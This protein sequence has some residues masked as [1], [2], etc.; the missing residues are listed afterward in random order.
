MLTNRTCEA[1]LFLVPSCITAT[2]RIFP[3]L[4]KYIS[5][6]LT[7]INCIILF[8]QCAISWLL[9]NSAIESFRI[10]ACQG[11]GR[12][13]LFGDTYLLIGSLYQ[14]LPKTKLKAA[15]I[16]F[17]RIHFMSWYEGPIHYSLIAIYSLVNLPKLLRG[18]QIEHT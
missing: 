14:Q 5:F 7:S 12:V 2:L 6:L 9:Q 17:A 1:K 15:R 3:P 10:C 18:T 4:G 16:R 13:D 11:E 8:F